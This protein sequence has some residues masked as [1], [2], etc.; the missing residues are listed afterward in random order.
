MGGDLGNYS[1]LGSYFFGSTF[2]SYF[3][4]SAALVAL[5]GIVKFYYFIEIFI[6]DIDYARLYKIMC[7]MPIFE[8]FRVDN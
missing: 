1:F 3:L 4:G 5:G 8:T 7:L 6:L 2:G